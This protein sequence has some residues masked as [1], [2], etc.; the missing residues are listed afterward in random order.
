MELESLEYR[1]N[2]QREELIG[3]VRPIKMALY[4]V[5]KQVFADLENISLSTNEGEFYIPENSYRLIGGDAVSSSIESPDIDIEI[6][7]LQKADGTTINFYRSLTAPM[8][9]STLPTKGPYE[10]DISVDLPYV[11]HYRTRVIRDKQGVFERAD[12]VSYEIFEIHPGYFEYMKQVRVFLESIFIQILQTNQSLQDF[13]R[14]C[15]PVDPMSDPETMHESLLSFTV[16]VFH[17]SVIMNPN[18]ISKIQL[19]VNVNGKTEHILELIFF[20]TQLSYF[21][22]DIKE[23]DV[24]RVNDLLVA[25]PHDLLEQNIE[26]FISRIGKK[27]SIEASFLKGKATEQDVIYINNKVYNTLIRIEILLSNLPRDER[28]KAAL[29]YLS[30]KVG[31]ASPFLKTRICSVVGAEPEMAN[32]C[33]AAPVQ[34]TPVEAT[35]VEAA[36]FPRGGA[37]PLGGTATPFPRG[38][39]TPANRTVSVKPIGGKKKVNK[40]N[41]NINA[42]LAEVEWKTVKGGKT[43]AKTQKETPVATPA[44]LTFGFEEDEEETEPIKPVISSKPLN[45]KRYKPAPPLKEEDFETL[46][47]QQRNIVGGNLEN[48]PYYLIKEP[49]NIGTPIVEAIVSGTI[50]LKHRDTLFTMLDFIHNRG[51]EDFIFV[52]TLPS[53]HT[54]LYYYNREKYQG[55]MLYE[56]FSLY[57]IYK[58]HT[59]LVTLFTMEIYLDRSRKQEGIKGSRGR[60]EK[61]RENLVL[62]YNS[63]IITI[64]HI[65]NH[66]FLTAELSMFDTKFTHEYMLDKS[67]L[68]MTIKSELSDMLLE[69]ISAMLFKLSEKYLIKD[70]YK[71]QTKEKLKERLKGDGQFLFVF[72]SYRAAILNRQIEKKKRTHKGAVYMFIPYNTLA[73]DQLNETARQEHEPMFYE[74]IT[75]TFGKPLI[76]PTPKYDEITELFNLSIPLNPMNGICLEYNSIMIFNT[77]AIF[78]E[79]VTII[80]GKALNT[81]EKG[82]EINELVE[83]TVQY[84]AKHELTLVSVVNQQEYI[85]LIKMFI[86]GTKN[87]LLND[88]ITSNGTPILHK[89]CFILYTQK[90]YSQKVNEVDELIEASYR[91]GRNNASTCDALDTHEHNVKFLIY[92]FK[93]QLLQ[94]KSAAQK[95]VLTQ[96]IALAEQN[97]QRA[98]NVDLIMRLVD[99]GNTSPTNIDLVPHLSF[100]TPEEAASLS[101]ATPAVATP[102]VATPSKPPPQI[103]NLNRKSRKSRRNRKVN[104]RKTRKSKT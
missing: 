26:A 1:Q 64:E 20:K 71:L 28:V 95:S 74:A 83:K 47:T 44:M 40:Q 52:Y 49:L 55:N 77:L 59:H 10:G 56:E 4:A 32:F 91:H 96:N 35:P 11:V 61:L 21:F 22:P 76:L 86:E 67:S 82:D 15:Q 57:H 46:I 79:V 62:L 48:I 63:V 18:F 42:L 103:N 30:E 24:N 94:A 31:K 43:P 45:V 12:K 99:I 39:S 69:Y 84:I 8:P 85:S 104:R 90:R 27:N 78:N 72:N 29:I 80:N 7:P 97:L 100:I 51:E 81:S 16:G 89:F 5:V 66:G 88:T 9:G 92:S 68:F 3:L 6:A 38:G 33:A 98:R 50:E 41:D 13:S 36:P 75:E 23:F 53:I 87:I 14:L 54:G 19:T 73:V 102:A 17:F 70:I 93:A 101:L 25:T 2:S 37:T 34:A 65:R 60:E 58:L